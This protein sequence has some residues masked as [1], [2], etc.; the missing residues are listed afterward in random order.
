[1]VEA[2]KKTSND[3]NLA[4]TRAKPLFG[5]LLI[6]LIRTYQLLLSPLLGPRCRFYPSCSDY[7]QQAITLHGPIKGAWLSIKRISH[8]H[9]GHPGGIDEV[10]SG[11]THSHST[12]HRN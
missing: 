12:P 1:M 2:G 9:P 4:R 7:A 5:R 6:G 11:P 8:C 10:P 3:N